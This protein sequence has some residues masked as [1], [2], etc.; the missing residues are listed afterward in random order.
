MAILLFQS[1]NCHSGTYVQMGTFPPLI[2][3][4]PLI[5]YLFRG[6]IFSCSGHGSCSSGKCLCASGFSG[7]DCSIPQ[8]INEERREVKRANNEVITYQTGGFNYPIPVAVVT[9]FCQLENDGCSAGM[10]IGTNLALLSLRLPSYPLLPLFFVLGGGG[11]GYANL[12]AGV[13]GVAAVN[14]TVYGSRF[15]YASAPGYCG[16]FLFLF[17]IFFLGRE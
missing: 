4:S 2:I 17:V 7:R 3:C 9:Q 5:H 15:A 13:D 10:C 8:G 12:P 1:I 6:D 16:F 11:L 14:P